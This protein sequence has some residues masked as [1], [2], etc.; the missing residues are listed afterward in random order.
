MRNVNKVINLSHNKNN[1]IKNNKIKNNI[2]EFMSTQEAE[3]V[4]CLEMYF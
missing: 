2:I 4:K 1:K 3:I